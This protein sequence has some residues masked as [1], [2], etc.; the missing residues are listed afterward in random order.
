MADKPGISAETSD[1]P[2]AAPADG[3]APDNPVLPAEAVPEATALPVLMEP[4]RDEHGRSYATGKRKEAV[5]RVWIAPGKAR[6]RS[7]A[8]TR[9]FFSRAPCCA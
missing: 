7:T 8:G 6:S 4:K 5:A 2:P 3:A 1:A 9:R